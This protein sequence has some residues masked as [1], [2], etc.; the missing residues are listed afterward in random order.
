MAVPIATLEGSGGHRDGSP[1]KMGKD[2]FKISLPGPTP[3]NLTPRIQ[4][5]FLIFPHFRGSDRG[6]EFRNFSP[7]SG[8]FRHSGFP[9]PLRGKTTRSSKGELLEIT[10][11]SSN[12]P[13]KIRTTLP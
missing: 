4:F 9:G 12:V 5:F 13:Q 8:D 11:T 10:L 7:F 3:E 6:G 1:R 2:L